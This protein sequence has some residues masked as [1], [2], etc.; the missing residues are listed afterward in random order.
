MAK[1]QISIDDELLGK[2]DSY[3]KEK[4]ITRSG[5]IAMVCS[6]HL[7]REQ[8]SKSLNTLNDVLAKVTDGK[9]LSEEQQKEYDD[10]SALVR[11]FNLNT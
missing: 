4:F 5:F 6:E 2:V 7:Q 10:F 9:V 11:L 8:L 1:V 3:C